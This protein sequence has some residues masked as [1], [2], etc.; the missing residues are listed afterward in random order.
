MK[1]LQHPKQI[2]ITAAKI[3]LVLEQFLLSSFRH[4]LVFAKRSKIIL[5]KKKCVFSLE[6]L[7][8]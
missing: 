3:S 8:L 1:T 6:L 4:F 5:L 2:D 7:S